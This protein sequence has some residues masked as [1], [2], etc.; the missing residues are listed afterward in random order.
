[1]ATTKLKV[2]VQ[3]ID[4]YGDKAPN[5]KQVVLSVNKLSTD[6]TIE[7]AS[8]ALAVYLVITNDDWIDIYGGVDEAVAHLMD[9]ASRPINQL[10]LLVS[11]E[12]SDWVF[13]IIE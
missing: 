1:M 11:G 10:N 5:A 2:L 3:E 7:L 6:M 13:N 8:R 9:S 4:R 12:E